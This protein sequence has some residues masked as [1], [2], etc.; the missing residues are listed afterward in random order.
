MHHHGGIADCC[1]GEGVDPAVMQQVAKMVGQSCSTCSKA[2]R[3]EG[4]KV[5]IWLITV[6]Y[7][8]SMLALISNFSTFTTVACNIAPEKRTGIL[9]GISCGIACED[10][11]VCLAGDGADEPRHWLADPHHMQRCTREV[12]PHLGVSQ[13]GPQPEGGCHGSPQ[14]A[15]QQA[16]SS[17]PRASRS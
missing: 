9:Q 14:G 6:L 16:Q 7:V 15:P 5:T 17:L 4:I 8:H 12:G 13:A 2:M 1:A 10:L 3:A 11:P